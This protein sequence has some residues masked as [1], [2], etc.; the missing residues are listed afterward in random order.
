MSQ[1]SK[2]LLLNTRLLTC[3]SQAKT[4]ETKSLL[5]QGADI[6]YLWVTGQLLVCLFVRLIGWL[7]GWLIGW[8]FHSTFDIQRSTGKSPLMTAIQVGGSLELVNLLLEKGADVNAQ[9]IGQK[10]NAGFTALHFAVQKNRQ[11]IIPSLLKRGA[12]IRICD[13]EGRAPLEEAK[14]NTRP[15]ID[16]L[17]QQF[18]CK[19]LAPPLQV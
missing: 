6:N 4:E 10:K 13:A 2:E 7:V 9:A 19:D 17:F 18:A 15:A 12:D 1:R 14:E 8:L 5:E 3:V 11:D 16:A